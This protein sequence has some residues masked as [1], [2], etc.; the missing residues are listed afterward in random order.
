MGKSLYLVSL[1]STN[2]QGYFLA[3]I[4]FGLS[5]LPLVLVVD[6]LTSKTSSDVTTAN[7]CKL[8]KNLHS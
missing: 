1:I 4:I 3:L 5:L 7:G 6:S 8:V 2:P